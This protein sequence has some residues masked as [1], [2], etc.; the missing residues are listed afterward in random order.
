MMAWEN[1]AIEPVYLCESHADRFGGSVKASERGLATTSQSAGNQHPIRNESETQSRE[2]EAAPPNGFSPP[3]SPADMQA[4]EAKTDLSVRVPVLI[5]TND[6]SAN[7]SMNEAMGSM[8][9]EDFEAHG[10]ALQDEELSTAVEGKQSEIWDLG[11]MCRS[12][13]GEPCTCEATVHCSACGAWFCDAHAEDEKW[14]SCVPT[15]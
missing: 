1:R 4:G 14:H 15:I 9:R 5:L 11:R 2:I 12:R 10:T 3:G 7:G 13:N 6:A 8:V